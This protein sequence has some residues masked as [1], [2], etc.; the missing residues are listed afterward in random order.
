MGILDLDS[1]VSL[2]AGEF[3]SG[4]DHPE[5]LC[6]AP[7]GFVYAGG[8]NGQIYRVN[9]KNREFEQYASIEGRF[10]GGLAADADSN[11]YACAGGKAGVG[12]VKVDKN[13]NV[14]TY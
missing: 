7:D 3:S 5:G 12:I 13:G 14:A 2:F 10:V 6:W 8:E 4:F 11:I 1:D 9:V